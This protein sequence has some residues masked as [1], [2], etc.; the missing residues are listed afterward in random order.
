METQ[1]ERKN[2]KA[3]EGMRRLRTKKRK[4]LLPLEVWIKPE[5]KQQLLDYIK[6]MNDE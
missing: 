4:T 3:R 2:R 5:H 6:E 1:D